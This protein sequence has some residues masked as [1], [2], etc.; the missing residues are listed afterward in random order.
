MFS[1]EYCEGFLRFYELNIVF[2]QR[3]VKFRVAVLGYDM[4]SGVVHKN[5]TQI[6][7]LYTIQV[8]VSVHEDLRSFC[9]A[10]VSWS[11]Y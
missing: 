10:I 7:V 11:C 9:V 5:K 2:S 1:C 6:Q 3:I 4:V 8:L